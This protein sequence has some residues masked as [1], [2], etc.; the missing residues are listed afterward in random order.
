MGYPPYSVKALKESIPQIHTNINNITNAMNTVRAGKGDTEPFLI[1]LD[2]EHKRLSETRSLIEQCE[3]RD[4]I[5]SNGAAE[6]VS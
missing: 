5:L 2:N 3:E 4:R 1:A 6:K